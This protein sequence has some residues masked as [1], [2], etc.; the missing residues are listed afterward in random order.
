MTIRPGKL[1]RRSVNAA[2]LAGWWYWVLFP[3]Q[4][5][6]LMLPFLATC[7]FLLKLDDDD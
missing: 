3:L 4:G 1:I 5:A 6:G 2:I 7:L